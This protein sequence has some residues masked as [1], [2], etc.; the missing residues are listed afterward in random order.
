MKRF[1]FLVGI[2]SLVIFMLASGPSMIQ[3]GQPPAQGAGGSKIVSLMG[4]MIVPDQLEKS[5]EFYHN[6]LGLQ[7]PNG[8][9]RIKLHWY[10]TV[11]FLTE[12][13]G[14][15]EK[16]RNMTLRIPGADIGVEPMQWE[17]SKGKLLQQRVQDPGAGQLVLTVRDL[18][19]FLIYLTKGGVK[20][21]TTGGKPVAFNNSDGKGRAVIVQD[22]HGY[23]VRLVEPASAPPAP[24][25]NGAGPGA[26]ILGA[27]VAVAVQDT[28]RAAHFYQDVLGVKVQLGDGFQSDPNELAILG[29]KGNV[30]YRHSVVMFP[31]KHQLHL[32]EFKGIDRK[33]I[34][35]GI[36]DPGAVV[37][38]V[39]VQ[40]IDALYTKLK[41]ATA[42]IVSKSG[43]VYLNGRTKWLMVRDPDN[44]Y[45][46]PVEQPQAPAP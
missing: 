36:I 23:F 12:M 24:G 46:Q 5:V 7:L 26:Y 40:G 34:H 22:F 8:D 41:A 19:E 13:Y 16:T 4:Y 28:E 10:E 18:D 1:W 29:M 44:I 37:L 45:V 32:F 30:S 33:P 38:R 21:V 11:P 43:Q 25:A 20:V 42:D 17:A 6:L 31:E 15:T 3:A 2:T 35:P 27:Q 14:V 9:P 39:R